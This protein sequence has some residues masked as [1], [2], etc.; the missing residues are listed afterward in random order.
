M[1]YFQIDIISISRKVCTTVLVCIDQ[2]SI[3]TVEVTSRKSHK[4]C[5]PEAGIPRDD[6]TLE[7]RPPTYTD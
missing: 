7:N 2:I 3:K 5:I 1:K 4:I 6:E